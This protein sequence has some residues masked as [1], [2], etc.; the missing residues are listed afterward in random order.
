MPE[1]SCRDALKGLKAELPN[2]RYI[3]TSGYTADV[4]VDD[5]LKDGTVLLEK[6]YDPG[7][8]LRLVRQKLDS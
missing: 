1:M 7:Q 4:N 5:L 6:P 2:A 8:L 3:L